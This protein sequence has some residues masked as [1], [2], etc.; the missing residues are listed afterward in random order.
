MNKKLYSI[1][2]LKEIIR[3]YAELTK[4]LYLLDRLDYLTTQYQTR[5]GY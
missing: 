4:K 3:D 1:Q 5:L 2:R